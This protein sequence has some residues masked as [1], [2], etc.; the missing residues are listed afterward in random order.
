MATKRFRNGKYQYV[1]KNKKLLP[2]PLYLTFDNEADG[3]AYISDLEELL[4][5][6][7][8]PNEFQAHGS[9]IKLHQLINDYVATV[10]IT[11]DK[12]QLLELAK[13]R[14]QNID[15]SIITY[16]WGENWIQD[17][18]RVRMLVPGTITKHV[19]ALSGCLDWAVS[20]KYM[21]FNPFRSLPKGY[22]NYSDE[23]SRIAGV[24]KEN[25]ERDR[26]LE[27]GEEDRILEVIEGLYKPDNRQRLLKPEP[28]I[29]YRTFFLLALETAMRMRE[30]YTLEVQQINFQKR[31]I[32]LKKTKNGDKRQV[33]MTT[34][35]IEL[36]SVYMDERNL[37][38][39]LFPE[40]FNGIYTKAALKKNTSRVSREWG[41]VFEHAECNDF[42]FHDTR[43]EATSRIY[44]RTSLSDIEIA[45][46]T[47]HKTLETLKR[48]ANLRGSNLSTRLW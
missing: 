5:K 16:K 25:T 47:G 34:P 21:A 36:L 15:I 40:F 19:G 17:M 29:A 12:R 22:S 11:D 32:F 4:S 44:E 8:V 30:L 9:S 41:R 46:I 38:K 1:V 13:K 24:F 35:A 3:D 14:I 48:Y 2:K 45:K 26:R 10:S 43:H 33:P 23:D 7:V 27:P 6:G 28:A 31:T 42:N 18:K 39:Y 20:H 37:D